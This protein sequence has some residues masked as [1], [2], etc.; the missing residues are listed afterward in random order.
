ME[1]NY[2]RDIIKK[3][4]T[5]QLPYAK[6]PLISFGKVL[7]FNYYYYYYSIERNGNKSNFKRLIKI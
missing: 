2:G 3:A 1:F 7:S 4:T 6:F 5:R